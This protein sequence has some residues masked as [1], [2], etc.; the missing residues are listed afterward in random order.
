MSRFDPDVDY[1]IFDDMVGGLRAGYFAYKDW[2]GGQFEFTVQDKYKGKKQI[3]WGKPSIFITNV[4]PRAEPTP[5]GKN[6][7]EWEWLEENCIFYEVT[8]TI[9]R[10]NT[11]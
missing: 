5:M 6:Q 9:F 4:D 8:E 3:K 1:A 10:A 11:D 2:L 7:I